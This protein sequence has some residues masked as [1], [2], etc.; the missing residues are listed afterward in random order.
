[1]KNEN[2]CRNSKKI[3][4]FSVTSRQSTGLRNPRLVLKKNSQDRQ[5]NDRSSLISKGCK[6]IR[7]E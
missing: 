6:V 3:N 7:S 2:L 1:M 5:T 4:E